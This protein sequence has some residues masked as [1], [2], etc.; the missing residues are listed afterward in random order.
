MVIFNLK[1]KPRKS[2]LK[3]PKNEKSDNDATDDEKKN[4]PKPK[5]RLT[6]ME[7]TNSK[8]KT[9]RNTRKTT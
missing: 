4:D 5:R 6:I 9:E 3:K 2:V 7:P 8:K 1:K